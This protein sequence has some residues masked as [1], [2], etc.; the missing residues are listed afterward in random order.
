M[1]LDPIGF[2]L[3]RDASPQSGHNRY[4][5]ANQIYETIAQSGVRPEMVFLC[6]RS[7]G[8]KISSRW[9]EAGAW[10]QALQKIYA[11]AVK[12]SQ[13]TVEVCLAHGGSSTT[14]NG[15]PGNRFRGLKA[16]EFEC[17]GKAMMLSP[18]EMIARNLSFEQAWKK[19]L[20]ENELDETKAR[21]LAKLQIYQVAQFLVTVGETIKITK[22]FR[23]NEIRPLAMVNAAACAELTRTM[24]ECMSKYVQEDGRLSYSYWPSRG[25]E[26][27]GNNMIRQFMGTVCLFKMAQFYNSENYKALAE[28][29]LKYNF[30]NFYRLENGLGLIEEGLKVKLGAV[31]L[32]ALATIESSEEQFTERL[33]ATTLHLSQSDGAFRTFYAPPERNDCQNFYPG[34]A[35]LFWVSYYLSTGNHSLL[36]KIKKSFLYY[37]D[38]YRNDSNPAFIPWHTQA[39]YLLW[40]KLGD[41]SYRD[42]IFEMNDWLLPVQQWESAKSP[43]VQ[44]QFYDPDRPFGPP[45]AS[46]TGVYL[47]GLIDA[48]ELARLC[49]DEHRMQNYGLAILRGVRSVMQLQYADDVDMFY[50]SKKDMVRG[51]IRTTVYNNVIRIDNIQ[52]NLMAMMKILKSGIFENKAL[53]EP[54]H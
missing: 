36:D 50:I 44:G 28:R 37:R 20:E 4:M 34:E 3:S 18:T 38:W 27:R 8:K 7:N 40:R 23:G 52:H 29:N 48:Y 2:S 49:H 51:A 14:F 26:G 19:F 31:A 33:F 32:A 35:L 47:E 9:C 22:M 41:D 25:V 5:T 42:F 21:K 10:R 13:A 39:Y 30:K 16:V 17:S 53:L 12:T 43:D 24:A 45:H 11:E 1:I 6:L 46:S 54:P 15:L